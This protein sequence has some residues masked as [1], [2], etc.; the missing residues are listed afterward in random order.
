Q[1]LKTGKSR[2]D[3][4]TAAYD[5]FYKGDIAREFVRGVQEEGGL[6]SLEDLAAW[7]VRVEEPVMT[8]YR[9]IE[10]YKLTHWTQGPAMLQALNILENFDLKG[11][12]FNSARYIHALYQAMNLAFADRDFYYGDPYFPPE[13]PIAGLLSKQYAKARAQA[14]NWERNDP[15]AKPGDPYPFMGKTNPYRQLLESWPGVTPATGSGGSAGKDDRSFEEA[16]FGGTTSIEAADEQGWVVSIT[17][18]GGWIPAVIAART[19]VGMSQRMQSFVL[20]EAENPCNVVAP[21]KG[22][23]APL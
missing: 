1:A 5:R 3:A 19:G 7:K 2:K 16:F 18:S 14:I 23:L 11:M 4:I 22:Q 17:P 13:E 20:K 12:G 10:V 8:T 15:N 21:G 9:G 6:I